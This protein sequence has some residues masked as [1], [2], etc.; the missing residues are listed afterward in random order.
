MGKV[1]NQTLADR[2]EVSRVERSVGQHAEAS[3]GY[4]QQ[5]LS[6]TCIYKDAT[7]GCGC[8][9][10][11]TQCDCA[12]IQIQVESKMPSFAGTV[13]G[14]SSSDGEGRE[15]KAAEAAAEKAEA[16]EQADGGSRR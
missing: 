8:D 12:A 1:G 13:E 15:E 2:H 4:R 10:P 3:V 16:S 14:D 5:V 7:Q 6:D 9:R 11:R